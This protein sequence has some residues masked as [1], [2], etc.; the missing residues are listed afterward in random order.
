MAPTISILSIHLSFLW[1]HVDGTTKTLSSYI[2]TQTKT[3]FFYT[4]L[5]SIRAFNHPHLNLT[6]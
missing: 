4:D 6:F 2:N 1:K 3:H 5:L